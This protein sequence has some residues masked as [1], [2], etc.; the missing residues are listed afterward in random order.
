MTA[1]DYAPVSQ[2]RTVAQ[3]NN[4]LQAKIRQ[5]EQQFQLAMPRGV[6]AIQLVRDAL[7]CLQGNPKLAECEHKSILGGLMTCAQLGLRPGVNVL[8]QAYLLPFWDSRAERPGGGKGMF[9]AQLVIGYQGY[10]ELAHRSGRIASIHARTVYSN[11]YFEIEYGAAEDKWVHRPYLDGPRGEPR[12]FYAVGRTV[13]GG[14]SMTDP[15]SVADM[16]TYRDRFATAKK[17]GQVFGPWVDHF[18]AMAHKTMVRRLM[19][20]LPKSTEQQRA[21]AQDGGVRLD[22]APTSIDDRPDYID[23][24]IDDTPATPPPSPQA[25]PEPQVVEPEPVP[26]E[27]E[28]E[29]EPREPQAPVQPNR[30]PTAAP[31]PT[32]APAADDP[33]Q[34][35]EPATA[36]PGAPTADTPGQTDRV[37]AALNKANKGGAAK[38]MAEMIDSTLAKVGVTDTDDVLAVASKALGFVVRDSSDLSLQQI[39]SVQDTVFAWKDLGT[40]EQMVTDAI[41]SA[42]QRNNN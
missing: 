19:K 13:D 42:D 17:N 2:N 33:Q 27:P 20:L 30:E 1:T 10:V 28:T 4:T 15:V 6:E 11:D 8:G 21:I 41:N 12:L 25:D 34:P 16:I 18:E 7:T 36:P 23:G 38:A 3:A 39:K 22:L 31:E 9:K 14:Y 26:A 40:L 32:P 5:M 24:E 35:E 37:T 29:P